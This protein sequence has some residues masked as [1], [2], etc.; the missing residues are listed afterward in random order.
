MLDQPQVAPHSHEGEC[1]HHAQDQHCL[2]LDGIAHTRHAHGELPQASTQDTW[3]L[4]HYRGSVLAPTGWIASRSRR[5]DTYLVFRSQQQDYGHHEAR[6]PTKLAG[7]AP[8]DCIEQQQVPL[9]LDMLR[10]H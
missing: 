3:L 9:R 1:P 6:Q 10:S 5:R 2:R 4:N 8:D 7:N